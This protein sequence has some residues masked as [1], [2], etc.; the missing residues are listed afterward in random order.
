MKARSERLKTPENSSGVARVRGVLIF[1]AAG[2]I[3]S[4]LFAKKPWHFD[5]LWADELYSVRQYVLGGHKV[6]SSDTV[7]FKEVRWSRRLW[8]YKKPTN[9]N[10]QTILSRLSLSAWRSVV[11]PK[12]LQINE[13]AVRLP[14]YLGGILSVGALALLLARVGL[15]GV[16]ILAAWMIDEWTKPEGRI[17]FAGDFT[18]MKNGWVE[19]AIES[20]LRA[21]RQIDPSAK[22]EAQPGLRQ[23]ITAMRP[24]S[25]L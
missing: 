4:P 12:G 17:H 14:A 18:T 20:G 11:R 10:F 13:T 5:S 19:G 9:H 21:A 25:S 22:P 3:G 15:P 24:A 7:K 1:L 16:G 6:D 23:E 8:N 2:I